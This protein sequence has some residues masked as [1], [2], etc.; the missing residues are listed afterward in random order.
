[1]MYY[2]LGYSLSNKCRT[3]CSGA[4]GNLCILWKHRFSLR[5]PRNQVELIS[6]WQYTNI[7]RRILAYWLCYMLNLTLVCRI[8]AIYFYLCKLACLFPWLKVSWSFY[9]KKLCNKDH[10]LLSFSITES[11]YTYIH[12]SMEQCQRQH[13]LRERD[14]T[15]KAKQAMTMNLKRRKAEEYLIFRDSDMHQCQKKN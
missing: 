7:G 4:L 13:Q 14:S 9:T 3:P 1:M 5:N 8:S 15:T 11:T 10:Y 12:S 6:I 2:L